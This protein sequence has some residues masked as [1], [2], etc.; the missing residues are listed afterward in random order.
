MMSLK[1]L[2]LIAAALVS[3]S[4]LLDRGDLSDC[5]DLALF[6]DLVL[7]AVLYSRHQGMGCSYWSRHS[8]LP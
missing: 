2:T 5:L 8:Q 1:A 7:I 4:N 3:V 6:I